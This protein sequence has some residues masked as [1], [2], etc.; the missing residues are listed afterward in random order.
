[1]ESE[2]PDRPDIVE[3]Y[4]DLS[5]D[6]LRAALLA[7]ETDR[8][9]PIAARLRDAGH[10]RVQSWSPKVFIPLTQLCRNLCH[11]CTFSQ[12][13]RRGEAA[14]LDQDQVLAIARAGRDAG[15]TEALFTLG[16]KPELRFAAAREELARLGHP[17]TLSYLVEMCAAVRDE[18]G[19]LPHVNAGVMSRE[20]LAALRP[21]SASMGLMLESVSDR[22]CQKGGPHYRSPDKAPAARLETLRL[23]GELAIP[24]TTGILIGIGETRAERIDA[25]LAIRNL[26]RAHG[27]IQEVIVQNFRA[28]PRTVM[29]DAPEPDMDDLLWTIAAARILLGPAMNIQAPPNLSADDFPRLIDAGIN[30]WGGVSPVTPDHVNPEAPWPEVERLRTATAE[31]GRILVARLPAYP[32]WGSQGIDRWQ[33]P[34]MVRPLLAAAAASGFARADRWSPGLPLPD[35]TPE[36]VLLDRIDPAIAAITERAMAG[37][38]LGEG[39]IVGLFAARDIDLEHVC[40][41]ADTLRRQV[42]GDTV[43]YAVNRNINYTNICLYKCGFCA[44]SKGDKAEALRGKPYDLDHDEVIRRTREA[45][46]RGATEVCLQGGIHPHYTGDT[47]LDLARAVRAAVPEM[48]IHAFSPLEV[49]Q[50]AATLNLS[51]R[52]FLLLLKAAGLDTL[53][54]TAA[55]ILDDE[56]RAQICPDK[57]TSDQWIDVVGTAHSVGFRTTAT[58][59]FGHVDTPRHWARHLLRIRTL[60]ART[61]G[62]TEF[63]PLPFVPM[64][65][66]M[67]LRGQARHGPTF[68]EVRLMHAVARLALHP[69]IPNIQASWVKL[70]PAGVAACLNAGA[71]DL[72]GTL[73]NESISRAAGTQHGQEMPPQAMEALIRS[74]GRTPR[75]RTTL[76]GDVPEAIR[77]R[78]HD[79]AALTPMVLTPPTK[80]RREPQMMESL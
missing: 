6:A 41:A 67:A 13:P 59:M 61:G 31:R 65:A 39:D 60:Q 56:V 44:F 10:G 42:H 33:D 21:V 38:A 4:A 19:L 36:P 9:L 62:F 20:E 70:G 30:D 76:Y 27:H 80:K 23:A 63:V 12:P 46:D 40:T 64:E 50:G 55:E 53:P 43:S 16:D 52:D 45:W 7:A 37:E 54:G 34:A 74:I 2:I 32:G 78:S 8:L 73:M 24:F 75:Q 47:Y 35:R 14:Y 26:H 57:L 51:V 71:N 79:A 15:C 29:A 58:I 22:L 17:T 66:P 1:M 25:L 48:H 11:Y 18:T 3:A 28:K 49:A 68:R 5:D 72:G 69:L 77:R